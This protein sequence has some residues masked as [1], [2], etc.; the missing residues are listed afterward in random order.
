M[1]ADPAKAD[2]TDRVRRALRSLGSH[3]PGNEIVM[4]ILGDWQ[5]GQDPT[6]LTLLAKLSL[7]DAVQSLRLMGYRPSIAMVPVGVRA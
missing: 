5:E 7:L 3:P 4:A 1:A 2:T 6:R